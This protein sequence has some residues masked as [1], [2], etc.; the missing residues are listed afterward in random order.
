MSTSPTEQGAKDVCVRSIMLM[1]D[2]EVDDFAQVVHPQATNRE[3]AA[4]PPDSRGSGPAAFH[5]T[6]LWL[7]SAYDD[8]AWQVHEAVADG[9]LVTLHTTM[10]GRH[11]RP[12]VVYGEDARPA[13]VFPPTGRTFAV[14]QSH[15]FRMR[16]GLVAEHW[17]NRDDLGQ[18][19]QL[20]WVPPKPPYLLAMWRGLRRARREAD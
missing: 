4:E 19:M 2:G 8:L 1:V 11:T 13:Q 7:R 18:A 14:T 12:F 16:D 3:G 6:A 20:G 5:S 10:R 9:D 15:W 17:A